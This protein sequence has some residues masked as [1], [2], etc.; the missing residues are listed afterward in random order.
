MGLEMDK[1][2]LQQIKD[3]YWTHKKDEPED[4][5]VTHLTMCK[6]HQSKE[7]YGHAPCDCGF[8]YDLNKLAFVS[9]VPDKIFPQFA[10]DFR[11]SET[12]HQQDEEY[13]NVSPEERKKQEEEAEKMLLDIFGPPKPVDPEETKQLDDAEWELIKEVFGE[14][15]VN[16]CKSEIEEMEK[17]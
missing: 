16:R 12:T 11:R 17:N 9:D 6:I 1:E 13:A 2:K 15:F 3:R 14:T 5:I 8:L 10:E 4:G 7:E